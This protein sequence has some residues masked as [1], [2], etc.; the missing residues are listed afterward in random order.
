MREGSVDQRLIE[1]QYEEAKA[2]FAGIAERRAAHI[3]FE[4]GSLIDE[5]PAFEAAS[6]ALKRLDAGELFSA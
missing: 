4:I 3:L 5:S 1:K 2:V 6:A